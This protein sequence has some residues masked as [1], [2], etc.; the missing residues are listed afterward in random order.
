M[1]CE[2]RG[3]IVLVHKVWGRGGRCVGGG[4]GERGGRCVGGGEGERGGRCVG[5]GEGE[6][7]G[8][9]VGG[10]EGERGG[11]CMG[12]GEGKEEEGAWEEERRKVHGRRKEQEGAWEEGRGKRRVWESVWGKGKEEEGAW[13]EGRGKRR[14]WGSVWGERGGRCMGEGEGERRCSLHHRLLSKLTGRGHRSV[15]WGERL[16]L[17]QEERR[18]GKAEGRWWKG[19]ICVVEGEA[20]V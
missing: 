13:E 15:V 10:R 2:G 1:L 8:R 18:K 16:M 5:G 7:G 19:E 4:E 3:R 14:V 6:R 9:C 12:G 20:G 11:R 17:V